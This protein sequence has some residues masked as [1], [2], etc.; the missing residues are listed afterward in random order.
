MPGHMRK[1]ATRISPL[2]TRRAN[3]RAASMHGGATPRVYG[4]FEIDA[5]RRDAA[6]RL[7]A[8][9]VGRTERSDVRRRSPGGFVGLRFAHTDL[10][11]V[12]VDYMSGHM[13][14]RARWISPL[15]TRRANG[16]TA[17]MH[18]GATPRAYG[19]FESMHGGATRRFDS[20]HGA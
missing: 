6:L 17:S 1:R 14:E 8:R 20:M 15:T 19:R 3:G 5:R 10:R 16:R 2:A 18:G 4:R 11:A 7:D 13:R 9:R 12:A